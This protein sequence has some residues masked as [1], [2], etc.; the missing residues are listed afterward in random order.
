MM[1]E[2]ESDL[3]KNEKELDAQNSELDQL[4]EFITKVKGS[5]GSIQEHLQILVEDFIQTNRERREVQEEIEQFA[6]AYMVK[7]PNQEGLAVS[8][9]IQQIEE[10]DILSEDLDR[11]KRVMQIKNIEKQIWND[12]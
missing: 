1:A 12:L 4:N 7:E 9:I 8:T 5:H 2:T 10:A 11:M 3:A 6:D